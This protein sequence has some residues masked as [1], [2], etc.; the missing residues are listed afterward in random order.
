MKQNYTKSFTRFQ[1]F[2]AGKT[3]QRVILPLK[4]GSRAVN[5]F[6]PLRPKGFGVRP[7]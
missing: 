5:P 1:R 7:F 6:K 2:T 4:N 3:L